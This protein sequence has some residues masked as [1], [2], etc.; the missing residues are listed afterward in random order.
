[1]KRRINFTQRIKI[2]QK[3]IILTLIREN[4]IIKSFN[5]VINLQNLALPFDAKVFIEVYY[6]TDRKRF[7]FGTVSNI[8]QPQNTD[9]SELG[10]LDNLSFRIK[11][12]DTSTKYG[13]ILA[14]AD[15]IKP[16]KEDGQEEKIQSILATE[17]NCD[18]GNQ[19]WKINFL[20]SPIL[21]LNKN[22][23]NIRSLA[24]SDPAFFFYVYPQVIKEIL[25]Y[26]FFIEGFDP[27]ETTDEWLSNWFEFAKNI[28][29]ESIPKKLNPSDPD[30]RLEITD[31]IDKVVREF[32]LLQQKKWEKFEKILEGG[33]GT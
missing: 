24:R 7:D 18:L 12:V 25:T 29:S 27:E 33:A 26:M 10:N 21:E 4:G 32:S 15:N 23:P 2:P 1:M 30:S 6:R 19:I 31:W 22:I 16:H 14:E 9:L 13:L 11:I 3:N 20:S 28:Y 8:V 17:F 5:A